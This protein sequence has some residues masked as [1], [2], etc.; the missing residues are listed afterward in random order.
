MASTILAASEPSV[1]DAPA[2]ERAK[3][4][5]IGAFRIVAKLGEGGMGVVYLAEDERL[6]RKVA[7]K[8][9]PD[10]D[11]HA[12]RQRFLREARAAAAVTH[13]NIA[14]I[15]EVGEAGGVSFIAMELVRGRTLRDVL[16]DRLDRRE[17][18]SIAEVVRI[19]SEV[20][21]G[22]AGAH[23]AGIIHRDLK[24]E[25]V[26]I[27]EDNR[28]ILLDFG[29]AKRLSIEEPGPTSHAGN[30]A[31]SADAA[32]IAGSILG[33]PGYMSPEQSAG[34]PVDC[35][36]D[37][38]SFGV[39][40]Y[41]LL[42]GE[43]PFTGASLYAVLLAT[44]RASV[45]PPSQK[46]SDTPP[47]LERLVLRCLEKSPEARY[48]DG[49]ELTDDLDRLAQHPPSAG[50]T[51]PL[52]RNGLVLRGMV[53]TALHFWVLLRV[54]GLGLSPWLALVVARYVILR[55]VPASSANV[56]Q[57]VLGGVLQI[58]AVVSLAWTSSAITKC[59]AWL[60]VHPARD[61]R[62]REVF[63]ALRDRLGAFTGT[64]LLIYSVALAIL[65]AI[66]LAVGLLLTSLGHTLS[67][68]SLLVLLSLSPGM[69]LGLIL[70]MSAIVA[71]VTVRWCLAF[72]VLA[73]ERRGPIAALRR[74]S[75]IVR[76]LPRSA[77]LLW[78][79]YILLIVMPA[80]VIQI[81]VGSV[82]NSPIASFE[83][84]MKGDVA[85]TIGLLASGAADAVLLLPLVVGA[86]LGY[87]QARQAGGETEVRSEEH[88]S[89]RCR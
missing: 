19:G 8:I 14:T 38:F 17:L 25:N 78:F 9:L 52:P 41:E 53:F 73:L 84:F 11:D 81:I 46:R 45:A 80:A 20:A 31:A 51:L 3:G 16:L 58:S 15:H 70:V 77:V 32:T 49:A 40:L 56:A 39:M 65:G 36:T 21:R 30:L 83:V 37:V 1:A 44:Q 75:E 86:A 2:P 28:V 62:A 66:S 63:A 10:S 12:R 34:A 50:A 13:P 59:T 57:I 48:R 79:A 64:V 33:T 6:H 26:M 72:A 22:L 69:M 82:V 7:L 55:F 29:I 68:G 27:S 89:P 35:R 18:S 23:K 67:A 5:Q 42:T 54:V 85:S 76:R 43:R 60:L 61:V 87:L 74:S 4:D 71:P 88:D 24:P 47:E